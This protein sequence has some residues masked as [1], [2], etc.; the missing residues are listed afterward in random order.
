MQQAKK[1]AQDDDDEAW[2]P[3][4][5]GV[6]AEDESSSDDSDDSMDVGLQL[7][8]MPLEAADQLDPAVSPLRM[9]FLSLA[10]WLSFLPLTRAAQQIQ[11]RAP[12]QNQLCLLES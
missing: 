9:L 1:P 8:N 11:T 12:G 4:Q 3:V 10:L 7:A 5:L 2:E 6:K